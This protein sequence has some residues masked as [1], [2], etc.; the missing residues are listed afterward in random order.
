MAA[1]RDLIQVYDEN[2]RRRLEQFYAK[3][4]AKS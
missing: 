1:A 2:H 4:Q 3:L